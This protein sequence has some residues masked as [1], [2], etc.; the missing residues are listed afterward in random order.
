VG[1]TPEPPGRGEPEGIVE[2]LGTG[3]PEASGEPPGNAD[4]DAWVDG[5]ADGPLGG[6]VARAGLADGLGVGAGA[7]AADG[8]GVPG[9]GV[10][11]TTPIGARDRSDA[12]SGPSVTETTA[13]VEAAS[14]MKAARR[15]PARRTGDAAMQPAPYPGAPAGTIP[16]VPTP[17]TAPALLRHVGL[18][19]D[20]PMPWGRPVPAR[21]PGVFVV[22]LPAPLATAP[23]ELT[24]V[25]KWLEH[26]PTLTVDRE[27]PTSKALAARLA[28]FW[29]PESVVL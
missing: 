24:R 19:A 16:A 23:L 27:R 5:L 11:A 15:T 1:G 8:P 17:L 14:R 29:L 7:E 26:V 21:R 10:G 9:V 2:P 18:L 25:G 3:Q 12:M 22:E 28:S 4:P 20:G 13:I 6:D